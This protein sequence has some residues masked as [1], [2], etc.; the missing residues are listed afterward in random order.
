M[1]LNLLL[2]A[3]F[4]GATVFLG[5]LLARFFKNHLDDTPVKQEIVHWLMSF[6]AGIILSAVTLVLVQKGLDELEILPMAL[7]FGAGAL[8]FM[9]VDK[10]L[11]AT[12]SKTSTLMALLLDFVPESIAMGALFTSDNETAILLAVYIGLQNLPEAFNSYREMVQ[13][14]FGTKTVLMIFFGLS[15]F[16]IVGALCGYHLL[17]DSSSTTAIMAVFASGGILY[18]LFQD[19]IPDS[20]WKGHYSSSLG[21]TLGYIIGIIGA[22][23]I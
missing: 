20:K 7:A 3:G 22:K 19:L 18:L 23:L 13:G 12:E 11:A 2:C 6:G 4:A 1:P 21:A 17:R 5:G 10:R 14:G 15:F 16:G 8:L 9:W